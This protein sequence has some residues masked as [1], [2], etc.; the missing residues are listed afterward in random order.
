MR[1]MVATNNYVHT[2][3]NIQKKHD[4]DDDDMDDRMGFQEDYRT[5][6]QESE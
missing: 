1:M 4:D 2:K 3:M 6:N 5:P